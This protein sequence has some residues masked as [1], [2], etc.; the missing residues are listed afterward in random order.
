VDNTLAFLRFQIAEY[1]YVVFTS[2]EL[3][4][5]ILADGLFFTP[6]A[7]I[8]DFGGILDIF[9]YV[10]SLTFIIWQPR[11][12]PSNSGA[13]L[14]MILRFVIRFQLLFIMN[15]KCNMHLIVHCKSV[16]S[17]NRLFSGNFKFHGTFEDFFHRGNA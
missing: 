16:L 5:K 2:V 12:I 14:L 11:E 17:A 6:K 3:F 8:R 9:I 15:S 10:V 1:T 4:L 13:Q 7:L